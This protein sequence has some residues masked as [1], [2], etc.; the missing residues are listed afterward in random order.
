MSGKF[1][2]KSS[3]FKTDDRKFSKPSRVLRPIGI[4]TPMKLGDGLFKMS[5][6]PV[7]ALGDNLRNLVMTNF[8]ERLGRYNFGTN[9]KATLFEL[10]TMPNFEQRVSQIIVNA[11]QEF[12]PQISINDIRVNQ[13]STEEKFDRNAQGLAIIKLTIVYSV[14]ELKSRD[15][16]LEVEFILGG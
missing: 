10:S 2:F 6:D 11:V 4:K 1:N 7:T 8:G 14:P 16:G 5:N 15:M 13:S 3:G 9:L 12:I